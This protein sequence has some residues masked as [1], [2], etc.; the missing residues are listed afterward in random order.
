MKPNETEAF[1]RAAAARNWSKRQTAKA[2]GINRDKF[3]LMVL[4]LPDVQW[5]SPGKTA[6]RQAIFKSCPAMNAARAKG[7]EAIRAMHLHTVGD[8]TATV[9]EFARQTNLHPSTI[10]RRM[11]TMSLEEALV[12]P[13]QKPVP[14]QCRNKAGANH[15]SQH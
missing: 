3:D 7:R 13:R 14:P 12:M 9:N 4:A 11:A 8:R 2:L 10:R 6:I 1:I 15:A 5:A